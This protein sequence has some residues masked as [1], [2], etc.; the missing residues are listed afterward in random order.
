MFMTCVQR[1]DQVFIFGDEE[2][3]LLTRANLVGGSF[4]LFWD[5]FER[6]FNVI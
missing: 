1:P 6:C 3:I 4:L 5:N 2:A